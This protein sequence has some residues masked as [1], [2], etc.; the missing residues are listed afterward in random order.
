M[1]DRL[2]QAF[3]ARADD[4]PRETQT[5]LLVT[6]L[7]DKGDVGEIVAAARLVSDEIADEH[8]A[9]AAAAGLLRMRG[10]AVEF[11]HPLIRSAVHGSATREERRA[12]HFALAETLAGDPDRSVWHRAQAATSPDEVVVQM[13]ET[14]AERA[15]KRGAESTAVAAFERAA[16]LSASEAARGSYLIRAADIAMSLGWTNVVLR[17]LGEAEPLELE[18]IDRTRLLFYLEQFEPRW[19]GATKVPALVEMA[20]A[21]AH[22]GDDLRAVQVLSD[23]AFRCWW[24]NPPPETR[25]LVVNAATSLELP[26]STPALLFV[27]GLAD[28]VGQGAEVVERLS[29][30]QSEP[31]REP[32]ESLELGVAGTAVWADDIAAPLPARGSEWSAGAGK[33]GLAC[34]DTCVSCLGCPRAREM[35][36][37]VNQRRRGRSPRRRN[38]SNSLGRRRTTGG[39]SGCRLEGRHGPRRADRR[40]VRTALACLRGESAAGARSARSRSL[41]SGGRTT[42]RRVRGAPTDLRS[43]RAAV[44]AVRERLGVGGPGR[45]SKPRR[46]RGR[47]SR[48]RATTRGRRS[49]LRRRAAPLQPALRPRRAR[50]NRK[51]SKANSKRR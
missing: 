33:V 24:G 2:Q 40:R 48:S 44:P 7:N 51:R 35:G 49:P 12:A 47:G 11:R 5:L 6:A 42:P 43:E 4:L 19:T 50:P 39:G 16:R 36:H 3:G 25:S 41:A 31:D 28:P 30:L 17:L 15:R 27:L 34:A 38:V 21:L 23:V 37:G 14:A 32:W 20:T 1:T 45:G 8:L 18:P 9:P 26:P 10:G 29:L 13:L 22:D 46:S